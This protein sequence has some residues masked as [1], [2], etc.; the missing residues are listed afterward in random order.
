V[1]R[2][3]E[4]WTMANGMVRLDSETIQVGQLQD[5]LRMLLKTN[6]IGPVFIHGEPDL[7][8]ADVAAVVDE[9]RGAGLEQIALMTR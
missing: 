2:D 7:E 5:R 4:L 1:R 9:V 6:V 3:I 8:F